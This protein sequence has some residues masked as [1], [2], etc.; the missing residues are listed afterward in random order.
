MDDHSYSI[1]SNR[2]TLRSGR[3]YSTTQNPSLIPNS[4]PNHASTPHNDH[5]QTDLRLADRR[6]SVLMSEDVPP[7]LSDSRLLADRRPSVLMSE[8]VPP[9]LIPMFLSEPSLAGNSDAESEIS[10]EQNEINFGNTDELNQEDCLDI[11]LDVSYT[12]DINN[13]SQADRLVCLVSSQGNDVAT[14]SGNIQCD[15]ETLNRVDQS[16]TIRSPSNHDSP[17]ISPSD[18]PTLNLGSGS[19]SKPV[20]PSGDLD[21]LDISLDVPDT[22]DMDNDSQADRLV[23]LVSSQGNDVATV[24]GNIQC[25]LETLNRVDQSST[26]RSPSNHDSPTISPSDRPALNLGSGSVSKPDLPTG[27]LVCSKQSDLNI[28]IELGQHDCL[29]ISFDSQ[30]DQLMNQMNDQ[31]EF[32]TSSGDTSCDLDIFPDVTTQVKPCWVVLDD[33]GK[34]QSQ[35]QSQSYWSV[36]DELG[37]TQS[38]AQSQSQSQP[39]WVVLDELGATQ[40]QSQSQ[41]Q[42]SWVVLDEIGATQSQSQSQSKSSWVVLDELGATQPQAQSQSRTR[43]QSQSNRKVKQ[44][45]TLSNKKAKPAIAKGD[46]SKPKGRIISQ[47]KTHSCLPSDTLNANTGEGNVYRESVSDRPPIKWPSIDDRE[48][49]ALLDSTVTSQLK[50]NWKPL[51]RLQKLEA[52]I[53]EVGANLFGTAVTKHSFTKG[54]LSRRARECIRLVIEKNSLAKAVQESLVAEERLGFQMALNQCKAKLR[55]KR[56]AE[57]KLKTKRSYS[58]NIKDFYKN[59]YEAG[60]AVLDPRVDTKLSIGLD[61]LDAHRASSLKDPFASIP[62]GDLEGLPPPPKQK[63]PWKPSSFNLQEFE[64]LLKSRRNGSAPG[65]NMIPYKVYKVCENLKHYLFRILVAISHSHDIPPQWQCGKIRFIPKVPEPVAT[66]INEYRE[67]TLGNVEGKLFFS[68][69]SSRITKHIVTNNA[70]V[71]TQIQKGCMK[72][73]PGCWEHMSVVWEALS[74]AKLAKKDLS[75][76]WL[77]LANAYGSV[78]HELIFFALKRYGIPDRWFSIVK[79]YYESLWS[80]SFDNSAPS[81]W[82]HHERG[83]FTGCTIS[84]VLFVAAINVVIEYITSEPVECYQTSTNIPLPPIRAFM[85][86]MNLMSS[87]I[88]GTQQLLQRSC[89]ALEWARMECRPTKSRCIVIKKGRSLSDTP[90]SSAVRD[91]Q[92]SQVIPSIHTNP[93]KF[94]G[95]VVNGALNDKKSVADIEK[96]LN[97][98]LKLIHRSKLGGKEKL[99]ILS[100]LLIA[101]IR[102]PIMIYEISI[103]TCLKLERRTSYFIRK[104]L[105]LPQS[106]STVALY[107]TS[108]PCALPLISLSSL[109]KNAKVSGY[110]QLRDST[111]DTVKSVRPKLRAGR[112]SAEEEVNRAESVI[113][114]REIVGAPSNPDM[115]NAGSVHVP[116]RLGVGLRKPLVTP[117]KGSKEHRKL[118]G[119]VAKEIQEEEYVAKAVQQ[120]VQ[121][122]WTRWVDYIRNDLTWNKMLKMPL[123]LISFAIKSTY[124]TLPTPANLKRW[125]IPEVETSCY[126]GCKDLCTTRH[127]LSACDTSLLQGRFTWRHNSILHALI[128]CIREFK[129]PNNTQPRPKHVRFVKEGT[130]VPKPTPQRP[131][132]I[133][134]H[135]TDWIIRADFDDNPTILSTMAATTL[136]PDLVIFSQSTRKV[137]IIELTSPVEENLEVRHVEKTA[138]Y[139]KEL[140]PLIVK[141][142]W[143]VSFF[144]IEVGARGYC[145]ISVRKCLFGLGLGAKLVRKSLQKVGMVSLE[146]SFQIW[147]SR[148]TKEWVLDGRL[149]W[150]DFVNGQ[151]LILLGNQSFVSLPST[152]TVAADS[153][154]IR[155]VKQTPRTPSTSKTHKTSKT[156]KTSKNSPGNKNPVNSKLQPSTSAK[157]A[158]ESSPLTITVATDSPRIREVKQTPRTPSTSKT[159]KTPKTSKNSPG[160]KNPV[161]SKL[162]PSTSA[163]A[164][165]ESS[166]LTITVAADSP[167][168]REVKQT[169]KTTKPSKTSK[170]SKTSETPKTSKNSTGNQSLVNSKLQPATSV[171]AASESSPL[172]ITV[173]AG[174][175][176][177]RKVEQTSKTTKPSKTSKR[178]VIPPKSKSTAVTMDTSVKLLRPIGLRNHTNSCYLNSLLQ[179]LLTIPGSWCQF[180]QNSLAVSSVVDH[181]F[182]KLTKLYKFLSTDVSEH[183]RNFST[184][185]L[186]SSLQEAHRK[187]YRK[188]KFSWRKQNDVAEVFEFLVAEVEKLFGPWTA[189]SPPCRTKTTCTACGNFYQDEVLEHHVLLDIKPTIQESMSDFLTEDY[190]SAG[191][192]KSCA[193]CQTQKPASQRTIFTAAP[194]YLFVQLKRSKPGVVFGKPTKDET[195]VDVSSMQ[196]TVPVTIGDSKVEQVTMYL[197]AVICHKGDTRSGHYFTYAKHGDN[198]FHASDL[199]VI[200]ILPSLVKP[201]LNSNHAYVLVYSHK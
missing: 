54:G 70:Y 79:N 94:L 153:P 33:I 97:E 192:V 25:D 166:P 3:T 126:L 111:D 133:L 123:T 165:S 122:H 14:V 100:N 29:S 145:S 195:V 1:P 45:P 96:K 95:R 89:K 87:S 56:K 10:V 108:S 119:Q 168:I 171:K 42:P 191:Q 105:R 58:R 81:S 149:P 6:P 151:P 60:K 4:P 69:V 164:A 26:I 199:E 114:F 47:D 110:L 18:R 73:I 190:L 20:L 19:V 74:D 50:A 61:E 172:T 106:I 85:D 158:S 187:E 104:W 120:V 17:T 71:N 91:Q 180:S 118:V 28:S 5:E 177:I 169:S 7:I 197:R 88:E 46:V 43:T 173:A 116:K 38:Q 40:A 137:V 140:V 16:S 113:T 136:R 72:N 194:Q 83:I 22:V 103:T 154:Q 142:K 130:K 167:Q 93:I 188:S 121:C 37:A 178:K 159:S 124:D 161:N 115:L 139:M 9:K 183:H 15:L 134:H 138:K 186:L 68:L 67:L 39:S 101:K 107:S 174:S 131:S 132:G 65:L 63:M 62:L 125:K 176:Q 198:W 141:N 2:R 59:P 143:T 35:S 27:A 51:M 135:A 181:L 129:V 24:S 156:P 44:Q 185:R 82:H 49:W 127:I 179:A 175:P 193:D 162:Q 86:D 8:D 32:A 155:E 31:G 157:A 201:S 48:K 109:V 150:A 163:K 23:C 99:W 52:K 148:K 41:S 30:T 57:R 36:L 66:N 200:K 80:K 147:L 11:S 182:G 53:Y 170:T 90:F 128:D 144:A 146:C 75:S 112:W 152:I 21:C 77:D 160:N 12:V 55:K 117:R 189:V 13:D 184:H 64:A 76:V 102:W 98:G 78:P 84:I 34:T 196:L 92:S